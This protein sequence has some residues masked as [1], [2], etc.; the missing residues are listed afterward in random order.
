MAGT[1]TPLDTPPVKRAH[2][3]RLEPLVAEGVDL[4]HLEA[5]AACQ[6]GR[7]QGRRACEVALSVDLNGFKINNLIS[8]RVRLFHL[9]NV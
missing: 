4:V 9:Y 6:V 2:K 8:K 1:G 5:G 7:G 3:D